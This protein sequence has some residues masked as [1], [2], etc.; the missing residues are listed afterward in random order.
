MLCLA[1]KLINTCLNACFLKTVCFWGYIAVNHFLFRKSYCVFKKYSSK[2][3][4]FFEK[5][6]AFCDCGAI[7]V[8]LL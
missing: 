4:L 2:S 8:S 5:V 7:F 1:Y 3:L 6:F